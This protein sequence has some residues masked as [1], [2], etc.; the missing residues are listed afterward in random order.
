MEAFVL[1]MS[2]VAQE[3]S[4]VDRCECAAMKAEVRVARE[5]ARM[6]E[7]QLRAVVEQERW[8]ANEMALNQF[9]RVRTLPPGP[10]QT[11]PIPPPAP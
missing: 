11:M 2:Y 1:L 4:K 3:W 8:M 7:P 6:C 9:G 10:P 5:Q